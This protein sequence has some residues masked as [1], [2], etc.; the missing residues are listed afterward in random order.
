MSR[1]LVSRALAALAAVVSTLAWAGVTPDGAFTQRVPIAVPAGAAGMHPSLALSYDSNAGDSF[2]GLGWQLEGLPQVQRTRVS[3]GVRLDATDHF[4]THQGVLVRAGNSGPYR[5]QADDWGLWHA[6]GS[7]GS[8]PCSFRLD[9]REGR[10]WYFGETA[11]ARVVANSGDV[12]IF[13]LSRVVNVDGLEWRVEY[14]RDGAHLYPSRVRYTFIGGVAKRRVDF[15]YQPR[16]ATDWPTS[17]GAGVYQEL[18]RRMSGVAVYSADVL[19]RRYELT[20]DDVE[21]RRSLLRSVQE[22]GDDDTS[23]LPAL[24][25]AYST[26]QPGPNAGGQ[27][28]AGRVD[29]TTRGGVLAGEWLTGAHRA[30]IRIIGTPHHAGDR[31]GAASTIG[32]KTPPLQQVHIGR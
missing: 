28:F 11:S 24:T 8:G 19:V 29:I 1:S 16:P 20:Y 2:A 12:A 21:R 17:F 5:A 14:V 30:E 3:H 18:R 4:V 6:E 13:A 26:E 22:V 23:R 15:S 10:R 9:D 32:A 27:P 25:F 7:C 31:Q